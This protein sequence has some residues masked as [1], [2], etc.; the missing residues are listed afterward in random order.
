MPADFSKESPESQ[1]NLWPQYIDRCIPTA[2]PISWPK[3]EFP[4][5]SAILS[6]EIIIA[7]EQIFVNK[8]PVN[9]ERFVSGRQLTI[10][11]APAGQVHLTALSVVIPVRTFWRMRPAKRSGSKRNVQSLKRNTP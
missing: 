7:T 11:A 3:S 9:W 10:R 4:R 5:L 1:N 8:Q 6:I 2:H